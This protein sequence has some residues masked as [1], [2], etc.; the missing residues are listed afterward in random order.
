[1][2]MKVKLFR[3]DHVDESENRSPDEVMRVL[4]VT[5]MANVLLDSELLAVTVK[6]NVRVLSMS[7]VAL[8]SLRS[9][10]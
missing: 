7:G 9:R 8:R 3:D 1:M 2:E 6:I 10:I 4:R 5:V